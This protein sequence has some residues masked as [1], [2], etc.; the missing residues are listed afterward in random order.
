[1]GTVKKNG[2]YDKRIVIGREANK[3][4][5]KAPKKNN[6]EMQKALKNTKKAGK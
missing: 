6:D 2:T 4:V 5:V 3:G 1:M